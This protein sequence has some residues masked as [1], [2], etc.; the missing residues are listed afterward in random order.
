MRG[1]QEWSKTWDGRMGSQLAG[2][3][4]RGG[5]T[6]GR[7]RSGAGQPGKTSFSGRRRLV[8]ALVGRTHILDPVA[9]E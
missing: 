8:G 3:V 7:R 4:Y 9:P 1:A 5:G 2:A 6:S